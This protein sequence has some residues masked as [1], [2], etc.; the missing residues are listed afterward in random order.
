MKKICVYAGSNLGVRP[1]FQTYARQLG[2][3]IVKRGFELVYGGSRIGLMGEVANTVLELGGAVTGVMPKGLFRGEIVHTGL[4]ELIEV[5]SMHQRK[6]TMIELAD[7]F[8][9]LPGGY[10]TFEELFEVMCWAQIGIHQKPIGI[11]NIAG[12]Y[13]PLLNMIHHAATE[14]FMNPNHLDLIVSATNANELFEK[15]QTYTPPVLKNK[16]RQ[17]A[18]E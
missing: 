4:S 8:V 1:E 11:F 10:G 16:W 17:L 18:E 5:D 3:E 12:Y 15:M 7:G 9:A 6:A 14:E 13:T 2:E